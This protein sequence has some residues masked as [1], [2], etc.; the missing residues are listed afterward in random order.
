MNLASYRI[1]E[2]VNEGHR[3]VRKREARRRRRERHAIAG[4]LVRAVVDRRYQMLPEQGDRLF[5]QAFAERL[6]TAVRDRIAIRS[7]V[8]L[9]VNRR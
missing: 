4:R 3:T 7:V 9:E 1:F 5:G 8:L 2:R 6:P